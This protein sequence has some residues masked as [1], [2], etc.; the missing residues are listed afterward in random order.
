MKT[1]SIRGLL[2]AA[3]FVLLAVLLV[4][5]GF[6]LYGSHQLPERIATHVDAYGQPDAW[7]ARSSLEIVPMIAV[8]LFLALTVVAAY[9]SLAK[10]AAKQNPESGPPFEAMVLKLIVWI[11]ME[12]MAIFTTIQLNAVHSARYPDE[13]SSVWSI[14]T[15]V[16]VAGIFGTVAWYVTMMIRLQREQEEVA[17]KSDQSSI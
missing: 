4:V 11:K 6:A 14:L 5:T 16:V 8:I 7:T 13:G 1:E 3:S 15:W 17:S 2:D 12:S 10:H 9:S